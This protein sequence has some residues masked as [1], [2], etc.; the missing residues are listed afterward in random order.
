MNSDKG[1]YWHGMFQ[2][3][4]I[5]FMFISII[6]TWPSWTIITLLVFCITHCLL[7]RYWGKKSITVNYSLFNS[8]WSQW[9]GYQ[10]TP[11]IDYTMY[12]VYQMNTDS[13]PVDMQY[14]R[15]TEWTEKHISG[16]WVKKYSNYIFFRKRDAVA[17]KLVWG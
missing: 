3:A 6:R 10:I 4:I 8:L 15:I 12:R 13:D 1:R 5:I 14:G 11:K 9:S 17:F 16:L 7:A 2:L